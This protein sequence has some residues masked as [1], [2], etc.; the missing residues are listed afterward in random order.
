[1]GM[2]RMCFGESD[3]HSSS[4]WAAVLWPLGVVMCW[5][6]N[7]VGVDST[8]EVRGSALLCVPSISL[9][10]LCTLVIAFTLSLSITDS[11][12]V[13]LPPESFAQ[14]ET[15]LQDNK[16]ESVVWERQMVVNEKRDKMQQLRMSERL[17][18]GKS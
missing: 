10:V 18:L 13:K 5:A 1:M 8:H 3:R 16:I 17:V 2:L 14:P 12:M 6:I 7:H 4:Q 15:Y 9:L 11:S